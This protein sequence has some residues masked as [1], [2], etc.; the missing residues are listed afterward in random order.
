MKT[1]SINIYYILLLFLGVTVFQACTKTPPEVTK[2]IP[3]KKPDENPDDKKEL[4]YVYSSENQLEFSLYQNDVLKSTFE[5]IDQEKNFRNRSKYFRPQT[6]TI[7]ADSL[8]ISKLG[9]YKESYKIK[10]EKEKLLVYQDQD[11]T[12]KHFASK[13]EKNEISLNIVHYN[14]QIKSE[15]SNA[16][17]AGQL[18]NPLSIAEILSEKSRAD[19]KTIWLKIQVIYVPENKKS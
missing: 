1:P 4:T 14:N 15:N 9:G 18:Y 19:M 13:N 3:E 6:M 8:L 2:E 7:R 17:R 12:W 16:S 5:A 10:W 11:K